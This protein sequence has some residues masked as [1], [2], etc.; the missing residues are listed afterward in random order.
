ALPASRHSKAFSSEVAGFEAFPGK[1]IPI[2]SIAEAIVF[3]VYIPPQEP[4]PGH[5]QRS[6][7]WSCS[8]EI[9]PLL[10]LLNPSHP[11]TRLTSSASIFP[12]LTIPTYTTTDDNS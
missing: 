2:A 5:A 12:R 10:Y 6:T 3:A 7:L 1:L 8:S 11:E 9:S 4:G